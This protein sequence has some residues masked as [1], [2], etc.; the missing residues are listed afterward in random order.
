MIKI[1]KSPNPILKKK[2]TDVKVIDAKIL[3]L[4]DKMWPLLQEKGVGLAAPQVGYSLNFTIIGFEPNKKQISENPEIKS[5][6]KMILINPALVWNSKDQSTEK[7]G[8]LSVEKL[9]VSVPRF[10]KIHLE[11]QDP[12]LKRHKIKA[13]GYLARVLQHE[14]DHLKGKLITDYL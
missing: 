8:C 7:E 3:D 4:I 11:Y 10:K 1:I 9:E 5:I 2:T 6:P 14:L 13:K 12:E